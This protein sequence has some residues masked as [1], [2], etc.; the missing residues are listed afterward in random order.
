MITG[1]SYDTRT[2]EWKADYKTVKSWT[3]KQLY[4]NVLGYFIK[5][6]KKEIYLTDE[7]TKQF[8]EIRKKLR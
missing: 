8:E 7:Q 2:G 4:K 6:G 3:F 5:V 1:F